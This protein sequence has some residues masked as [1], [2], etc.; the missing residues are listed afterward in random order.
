V[1]LGMSEGGFFLAPALSADLGL[2]GREDSS[3]AS[4]ASRSALFRAGGGG[5][6]RAEGGVKEGRG[7]GMGGG[8]GAA[9]VRHSS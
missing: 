1:A 6:G 3:A 9:E 2:D 5:A 8:K 7:R 4:R